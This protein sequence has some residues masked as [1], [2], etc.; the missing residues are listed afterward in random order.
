MLIFN[1]RE[2]NDQGFEFPFRMFIS[3]SSQSGKTTIAEKILANNLFS[4]KIS[5]VVY[6]HPDYL[7]DAP[8]KWHKSLSVPV[9][10]RSGQP[11]LKEL[12]TLEE[13]T[14]VVLDDI[15]EECIHSRPIDYLFR[16][17]SGKKKISVMIMSQR[18]F[19]HGRYSMN[20]RNNVNYTVLLRNTDAR[21]NRQ[22]AKLLNIEKQFKNIKHTEKYPYIFV[23]NSPKALESGYRVYE[24]I[25]AKHKV[26]YSD[27]GMRGYVISEKEFERF[28]KVINSTTAAVKDEDEEEKSRESSSDRSPEREP[29]A[30]L[31]ST[32]TSRAI[33][34]KRTIL[35]RL[36]RRRTE[37]KT[38]QALS[39][40]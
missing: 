7:E 20:V 6:F 15:Y 35:E 39:R 34:R 21:V 29:P 37:R 11:T 5:S 25:F 30:K 2:I 22:I 23:D 17:L 38:R 28:F 1:Y 33:E 13:N 18:Y 31:E 26:V 3:G 14:C 19:A 12:T 16:V 10:Y 4:D 8:V 27:D 40:S 36:K 32:E 9:C 24:D